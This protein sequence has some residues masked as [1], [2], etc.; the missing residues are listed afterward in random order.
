MA[1]SKWA[2]VKARLELVEKWARDGLSDKQ[3]AKNL[4]ISESLIY[5]YKKEHPDFLE[6]LRRGR[7]SFL[8]EVETALIKRALGIHFIESK[9]YIKETDGEVTRYAEKSEKYFPPSVGACFIL[10]KNKDRGNWSNN[11][12]Q[13]DLEREHLELEI[14][15]QRKNNF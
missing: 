3:L 13:E 8:A 15:K 1:K 12:V 5:V 9:T 11:P 14:E 6:S 10:L 7:E 4:G 2:Q